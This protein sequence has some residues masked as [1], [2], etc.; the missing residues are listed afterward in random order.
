ML[1]FKPAWFL[2]FSHARE[3]F[4]GFAENPSAPLWRVGGPCPAGP[5]RPLLPADRDLGAGT[6]C[7]GTA[8]GRERTPK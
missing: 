1:R 8:T 3:F 4:G 6:T 2:R 7:C 5:V